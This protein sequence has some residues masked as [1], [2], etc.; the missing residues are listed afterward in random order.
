MNRK[1]SS[2]KI[3]DVEKSKMKRELSFETVQ[4]VC[5]SQKE[6]KTMLNPISEVDKNDKKTE[7]PTQKYLNI[8]ESMDRASGTLFLILFNRQKFIIFLFYR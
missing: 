7:Q 1:G 4:T 6:M 3:N 2:K 8:Y 5:S